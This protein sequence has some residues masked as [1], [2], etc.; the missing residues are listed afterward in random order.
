MTQNLQIFG[1]NYSPLIQSFCGALR[2]FAV[3]SGNQSNTKLSTTVVT[4]DLN[5]GAPKYVGT[6][7]SGLTAIFHN[8]SALVWESLVCIVVWSGIS[9]I[10]NYMWQCVSL[11]RALIT[12]AHIQNTSQTP[13]PAPPHQHPLTPR[14]HDQV[15]SHKYWAYDDSQ[16][17]SD[18][19]QSVSVMNDKRWPHVRRNAFPTPHTEDNICLKFTRFKCRTWCW[20]HVLLLL[21]TVTS[22]QHSGSLTLLLPPRRC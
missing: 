13:A 16:P 18:V 7:G 20:L 2:Q 5:I 17:L 4:F 21:V 19:A 9:C 8:S 15:I 6:F 1:A 14:S 22:D 12:P 11:D 10:N 3:S